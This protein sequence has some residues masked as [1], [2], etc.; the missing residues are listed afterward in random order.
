MV[1]TLRITSVLAAGMAIALISFS[2]VYG[3]RSDTNVDEILESPTVLEQL[4]E[5]KDSRPQQANAMES[6]LVV[7]AKKFALHLNPPARPVQKPV[8][9]KGG[10]ITVRPTTPPP[11]PAKFQVVGISHS[12]DPNLSRAMISET[13]TDPR[14]VC[15]EDSIGHHKVIAINETGITLS[16]NQEVVMEQRPHISLV[17]KEG[18]VRPERTRSVAEAQRTRAAQARYA[19]P[20]PGVPRP[21]RSRSIG[22]TVRTT[23]P[24]RAPLSD[25]DTEAMQE[26]IQKL[27]SFSKE[28]EELSPEDEQARQEI[29]DKLKA[30]HSQRLSQ[31]EAETLDD[32]GDRLDPNAAL[33]ND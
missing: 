21:I 1:N 3:F 7:Q 6:R 27:H 17:M 16:N 22:S 20:Q 12:T 25:K 14:W 29:V 15:L 32:L 13:G 31:R 10:A 8:E 5:T 23:T 24:R 19:A 9:S 4:E 26:L 2:V 28:G 33:K 18:E 11:P 30:V